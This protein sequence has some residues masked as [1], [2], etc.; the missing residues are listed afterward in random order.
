MEIL[1]FHSF[2]LHCVT[3]TESNTV[4]IERIMVYSHTERSSDGILTAIPL[5]YAVFLVILAIEIKFK[6]VNY[7]LS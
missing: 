5:S 1:Y 6:L 3:V 4:V 7:S 2:L